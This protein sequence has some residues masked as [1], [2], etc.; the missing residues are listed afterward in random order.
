MQRIQIVL[1]PDESKA[2]SDYLANPNNKAFYINMP[3]EFDIL[4][5]IDTSGILGGNPRVDIVPGFV[6]YG[7]CLVA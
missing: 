5:V 2:L 1:T 7:L 6:P 3:K 4:I